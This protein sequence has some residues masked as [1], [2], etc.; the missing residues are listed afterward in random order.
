ML[1]QQCPWLLY[2]SCTRDAQPVELLLPL[3]LALPLPMTLPLL[4]TL[5][6]LLTLPL[7]LLLLLQVLLLLTLA[8]KKKSAPNFLMPLCTS[9]RNSCLLPATTQQQQHA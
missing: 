5:L 1:Y 7:L 3:L 4:L 6:L 8:R 2:I 9:P